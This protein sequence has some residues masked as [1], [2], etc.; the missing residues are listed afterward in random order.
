MIYHLCTV[1]LRKESDCANLQEDLNYL[2]E[3]S[4]MW[5]LNFEVKECALIG[6]ARMSHS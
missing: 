1:E 2:Y 5:K 3:W 4:Q 6:S